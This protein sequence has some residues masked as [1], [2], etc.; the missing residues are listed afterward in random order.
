[1]KEMIGVIQLRKY[2]AMRARYES[3]ESPQ[4]NTSSKYDGSKLSTSSTDV[5]TRH[6]KD[7]DRNSSSGNNSNSLS[8][9]SLGA[10]RAIYP[11]TDEKGAVE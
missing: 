4:S 7:S 10:G 2:R 1:M 3:D 6:N 11:K 8:S 5:S 9:R